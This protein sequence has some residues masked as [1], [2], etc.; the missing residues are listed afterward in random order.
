MKDQALHIHCSYSSK[1]QTRTNKFVL[2]ESEISVSFT[3]PKGELMAKVVNTRGSTGNHPTAIAA[4]GL[5]NCLHLMRVELRASKRPVIVTGLSSYQLA[6]LH[7]KTVSKA[8]SDGI[9]H[10]WTEVLSHLTGGFSFQE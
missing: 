9:N 3:N 6:L 8:H 2:V 5:R 10:E 1:E 4:V 7:G